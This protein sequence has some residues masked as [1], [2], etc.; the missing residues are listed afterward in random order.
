VGG[1]RNEWVKVKAFIPK[2]RYVT[3]GVTQRGT[4]QTP[5][6]KCK[7][8]EVVVGW[9]KKRTIGGLE[10]STSE[11]ENIQ[12]QNTNVGKGTGTNA[13]KGGT[14]CG[15]NRKC[16]EKGRKLGRRRVGR[17]KKPTQSV[18]WG[19]R[20]ERIIVPKD[21]SCPKAEGGNFWGG[22]E[23][24]KGCLRGAAAI[25]GKKGEQDGGGGGVGGCENG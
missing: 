13:K 10:N 7:R 5:L 16:R 1:G 8:K 2:R 11:T 9:K 14:S 15:R 18:S 24:W 4:G 12:S 21:Q 22:W 6:E 3:W 23:V 20:A 25:M 17:E 19:L